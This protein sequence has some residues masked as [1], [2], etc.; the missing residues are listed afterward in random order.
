MVSRNLD[1]DPLARSPRT[2]AGKRPSA[3]LVLA[4]LALA[5]TLTACPEKEGPA[6]KAGEAVDEAFDDLKE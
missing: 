5:A 6:E 1:R 3:L 4:A 2:A